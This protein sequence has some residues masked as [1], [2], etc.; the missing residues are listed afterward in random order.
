MR[1]LIELYSGKLPV[2][3]TL[4]CPCLL[5]L[6][7]KLSFS[8][9]FLRQILQTPSNIIVAVAATGMYRL[10]VLFGSET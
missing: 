2:P 10:L 8:Y 1:L 9:A 6:G 4:V 3:L 5:R 7:V